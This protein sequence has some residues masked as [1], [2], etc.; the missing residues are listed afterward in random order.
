MI[1]SFHTLEKDPLVFVI[2]L[3]GDYI[4]RLD[5]R[6][7]RDVK[8]HIERTTLNRGQIELIHN[9]INEIW[10]QEKAGAGDEAL[11]ADLNGPT[12]FM[13]R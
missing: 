7:H 2:S 1:F 4:G 6:D 13:S 10:P 9:K 12:L 5:A 3:D 11:L 8:L